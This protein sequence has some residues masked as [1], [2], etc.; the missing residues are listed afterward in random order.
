MQIAS[1]AVKASERRPKV[2]E[3]YLK[4]WRQS[5]IAEELGTTQATISRDLKAMQHEWLKASL[6][7]F[8]EAVSKEIAKIDLLEITYWQA[9][10]RSIEPFKSKTVKAR[11]NP[12]TEEEL[13]A[14]AEQTLKTEDRN[15]DPRYLQGVQWCIERR[16][17]V[18]GLD[19]PERIQIDWR[20]TLPDGI[21]LDDVTQQFNELMML[22]GNVTDGS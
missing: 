5:R 14:T 21:T 4:G 6:I 3:L 20:E 17:K 1:Q 7:S 19:A 2:A 8:N 11:G 22:A 18:L 15:G 9:W 10:E 16:I 12:R 13:K